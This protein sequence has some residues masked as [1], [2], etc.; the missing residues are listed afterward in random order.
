MF[1]IRQGFLVVSII[2]FLIFYADRTYWLY[3]VY[4]Y[5]SAEFYLYEF[6]AS[7]C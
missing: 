6:Q 7:A 5:N 4:V 2:S 1:I 3:S